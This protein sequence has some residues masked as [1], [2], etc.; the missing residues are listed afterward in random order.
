[1]KSMQ[2]RRE[3]EGEEEYTVSLVL[4]GI[5]LLASIGINTANA[6]LYYS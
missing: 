3:G 4:I 6:I 1:M 2:K 5:F